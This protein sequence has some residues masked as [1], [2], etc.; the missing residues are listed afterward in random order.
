MKIIANSNQNQIINQ[1]E[2]EAH[3]YIFLCVYYR[4]YLKK[5]ITSK[6]LEKTKLH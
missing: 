3:T 5:K 4:F 1:L 2:K 6:S